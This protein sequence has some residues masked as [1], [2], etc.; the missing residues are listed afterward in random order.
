M[1]RVHVL[2]VAL[3]LVISGP[4]LCAEP[5]PAAASIPSAGTVAATNLSTTTPIPSAKTVTIGGPF[6]AGGIDWTV[7]ITGELINTDGAHY[8]HHGRSNTPHYRPNAEAILHG[9]Q[10]GKEVVGLPIQGM[11]YGPD[12]GETGCP[13][14]YTVP[15]VKDVLFVEGNSGGSACCAIVT[16]VSISQR[17]Q[18]DRLVVGSLMSHPTWDAGALSFVTSARANDIEMAMESVDPDWNTTDHLPDVEVTYH[19]SNGKFLPAVEAV[20]AVAADAMT[21]IGGKG[22]V[23]FHLARGDRCMVLS[24]T[25]KE[26]FLYSPKQD[27]VGYLPQTAVKI[28]YH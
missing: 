7:T 18:L 26:V 23:S 28:E 13:S 11:I 1:N 4:N 10:D 12:C 8:K 22:K 17:R 5:T 27:M 20:V 9:I 25:K 6:T 3:C 21:R 19:F 24:Q 14:L 2:S 16:A 15:E